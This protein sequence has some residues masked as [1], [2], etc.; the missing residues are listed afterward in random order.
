MDVLDLSSNALVREHFVG[1]KRPCPSKLCDGFLEEYVQESWQPFK[2]FLMCPK[3]ESRLRLY[4]KE[5]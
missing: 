3:C 4:R 2:A 5:K 1:L